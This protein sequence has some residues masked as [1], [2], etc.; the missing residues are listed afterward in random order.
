MSEQQTEWGGTF[1]ETRRR[2][3][4]LGLELTLIERLAWLEARRAEVARLRERME[5]TG[6][7]ADPEPH[8][9]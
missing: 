5:S 9:S 1:E 7:P 4:I 3:E 6:R 8:R 2:Q